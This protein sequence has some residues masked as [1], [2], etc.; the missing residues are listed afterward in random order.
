MTDKRR[1]EVL[2]LLRDI[3]NKMKAER[4]VVTTRR[5]VACYV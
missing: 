5:D 1:T 2:A 3:E 4:G